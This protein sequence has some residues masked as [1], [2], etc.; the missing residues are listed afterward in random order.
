MNPVDNFIVYTDETQ[1][2]I[3]YGYEDAI[4]AIHVLAGDCE[5]DSPEAR[6][7]DAIIA[8]IDRIMAERR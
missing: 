6:R 4:N 5:T 3:K 7:R 8:F 1:V 2:P